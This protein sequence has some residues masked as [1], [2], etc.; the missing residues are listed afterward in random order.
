MYLTFEQ[1]KEITKGATRV[2][3]DHGAYRFY[4][5]TEAEDR[6][7]AFTRTWKDKTLRIYVNRSGDPWDIPTGRILLGYNL[8]I[9]APDHLTLGPR[10]FCIIED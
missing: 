10:G 7:L 8:Q 9:V 2:E 3:E 6:H 5:F 1:I 4:R